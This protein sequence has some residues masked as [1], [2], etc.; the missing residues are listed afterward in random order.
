MKDHYPAAPPERV[1][2][3]FDV[4]GTLVDQTSSLRSAVEATTD[5]GRAAAASLVDDWM[6]GVAERE[7][8]IVRG[9]R[10][11]VPSERLDVEVLE[12]LVGRWAISTEVIPLLAGASATSAPWKGAA[13]ALQ[14][15]S[16]VATV[17][18][19]SNASR[20]VLE[21]LS[22]GAGFD[23]DLLLSAEDVGT[24][25]PD[26]AMYRLAMERAPETDEPPFMVAAHAWD[27][28]A[29]KAVGMRT[30]YVPR[31]NG[32]PPSPGDRFDVVATDL[33]DLE[34]QLRARSE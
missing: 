6:Q 1:V 32:D 29:A 24:Y 22:D 33:E 8:A 34:R 26:A 19:L 4:L 2:A 31:P 3:V 30:A 7:Q 9:E 11:F 16:A 27:L 20:R 25:K 12:G 21:S 17:A 18:G 10:E 5:L 13:S 15:I 28:R 14:S 23:W